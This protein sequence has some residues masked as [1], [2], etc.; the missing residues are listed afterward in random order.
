MIPSLLTDLEPI[1]H[2]LLLAIALLSALALL[3]NYLA[4]Q[5]SSPRVP[6]KLL[7]PRPSLQIL[8]KPDDDLP[9]DDNEPLED[10]NDG[11]SVF[12]EEWTESVAS[13]RARTS[14]QKRELHH[15]LPD[16]FAPLLSSSEMELLTQNL[17]ADLLHACSIHAHGTLRLGRH[18]IP[19]N[20]NEARPQFYLDTQNESC[21]ISVAVEMGSQN[22]SRERDLNT[23]TL[24]S[25]RCQTMVKSC[26]LIFDPP[27]RLGNV[28]PTLLHFPT[29]FEDLMWIPIIRGSIL[30]YV[31]DFMNSIWYLIEKALW[32]IERRCTVHL[33]KVKAT[34]LYYRSGKHSQWRL[35]LSFSGYVSLF[36]RIPLPFLN[37][38]LPT[39]IIP[40]PH[41]L[42]DKLSTGQPLASARLKRENIA[43][44]SIVVAVLNSL[45][46]WNTHAV[47]VGTPPALEVDL[48]MPGG[49]SVA[50][51]MMHGREN[52]NLY[53]T[54][55]SAERNGGA[56]CIPREISN[57]TLST[58]QTPHNNEGRS[59]ASGRTSPHPH[60]DTVRSRTGGVGSITSLP[61][62]LFDA[63]SA[64]PW[65]LEVM[66]NGTLDK[67]KLVVNI[68]V[69]KAR[70]VDEESVVPSKSTVTLTGSVVV[71]R[72]SGA[73]V[74]DRRPAP[75]RP[76][77]KRT[78]SS[79]SH[80][81]ALNAQVDAPP[82]HALML[83]PDTYVPTT[84]RHH[85]LEY[86]Y[87]FDV[88]EETHLDA[89]SIS[90]GASHPML[91]GGTII[92]CML[93]S[94]YAY[95]TIFARE[96]A[97]AD[98]SEKLRK[99]N[100]L[101]HLPAVEFTAGIE[102]FYLP[103]QSVSY[104]DDG[105]TRSIPEI[106][107]GRLMF[108]VT[109]GIDESM[110]GETSPV[111]SIDPAIVREGIKFIADF[112]VSTFASTSETNVK[113]FPELD[114]FEG[115]KLC[116]FVLGTFD[117]SVMCHLRPQSVSK[118]TSLSSTTGPNVFN[119]LEAYEIDFSGSSVS[120]R[121]KESSFNL[122]HR[123]VIVPTESAFA[124]KVL[125]S[126]VNMSFEGTTQCEL[127]WD[128][129]GS[130]P[131]LQVTAPGQT[132]AQSTHENRQQAPLLINDLC[133]GR[134]NLDVSSVGGISF[135]RASTSR[136]DKQ[137]LYD[138][139]FFNALVSPDEDSP[140]RIRDVLYDKK[141]MYQ[142]LA[143][144]KLL[145]A[146]MEKMLRHVLTQVWRA[147]SIF[148]EEGISDPGHALPSYRL[149][150]LASLFLCGDVSEVE[151]ILP[152]IRRVVA[153]DGLDIV[154]VKELLR[155]H[156]DAYDEWAAEIDR[157][158]KWAAAALG[159]MPTAQ[160]FVETDAPP[161][162]ETIP[163]HVYHGVP[164]AKMLYDLLQDKPN[165]PLD[166]KFSKLV[167][168]IA[169]Y[170]TYRQVSYVL[171]SRPSNHWQAFDLK[172]LR[173]V[174]T[175]KKK[176]QEVA[177]SYGGLSFMPQSFFLSVF[178]GEATRS[179]LRA[180]VENNF[181]NEHE[182]IDADANASMIDKRTVLAKLRRRRMEE[183]FR[184]SD[185]DN[186]LFIM[187]PAG[188]IA[189]MTNI[190]SYQ[191]S[192]SMGPAHNESSVIDDLLGDS[193]L[194][195]QDVAVLLQA[196]LTS[197]MKGSTVVQ[198]NQ[199]M[200]LDLMASQPR[201][202][203]TAVLAELGIGNSRALTS[204][205][206]VSILKGSSFDC[207][208]LFHMVTHRMPFLQSFLE[209]DQSSFKPAHR[210]DMHHLL[211]SWLPGIK[212]P[213]REDYLAGGRWARQSYYDAMVRSVALHSF[214][215]QFVASLKLTAF[216]LILVSRC[217]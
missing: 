9:T 148:D 11:I 194:G 135:T 211:E 66:A 164:T 170:L 149:A 206:M 102:N 113:E 106:D 88:G 25:H 62:K 169:P 143:V 59:R 74:S 77:H 57:E 134:L 121:L 111:R 99:R 193:L 95:G 3:Q 179:S 201:S 138:W 64:V 15:G 145:N 185:E 133:Q 136:E 157:G 70:H 155:K 175:I 172:R 210:I 191:Q 141:T 81:A 97:I 189:S 158:V 82:I 53:S 208:I 163:E 28:T 167:G 159:P 56:A 52:G 199:R 216:N 45:A 152:I 153:A 117:G 54:K 139:K 23:N 142:L 78:L 124:V 31:L 183:N 34:P 39:F 44:E 12:S 46:S 87:E 146:D 129:Q 180:P 107:G 144:V 147:K 20:K 126:V 176:V 156:V 65:H 27:L 67:D 1:D 69:C 114:V 196:G 108:R 171:Q 209:M 42:I 24:T 75:N 151:N 202:F 150:R 93:E 109:G 130:S 84:K 86:D 33:G 197:A 85:L 5:K 120:L 165:L 41:A 190:S 16:S 160:P 35:S 71:C 92:S 79:N 72:A 90:Y 177:E 110:I 83:F 198:L 140:T 40:Q 48:T 61:N 43:E 47:V 131:V 17:T 98:P 37:I 213:K 217:S 182:H 103:K 10:N 115:S 94:I 101:R 2:H 187:S 205:L 203:A 128:F 173:Y 73:N 184:M 68:P 116:S 154:G 127:S 30:C 214:R 36:D 29:L 104:F 204:A 192:V 8:F 63:N 18:T 162:C 200:L 105:N 49:I 76:M 51:E 7:P 50:V 26:E 55:R 125:Q 100:I 22:L 207:L 13:S 188:R 186:E 161:L 19:L 112:G 89:V 122:G 118:N 119:P 38:R 215:V 14:R 168:R 91:N 4:L 212:I 58:W 60:L 96:G 80:L 6:Y 178:L 32:Y 137:G 195:P 166:L 174:Y 181:D 132:L 21:Q 123:R